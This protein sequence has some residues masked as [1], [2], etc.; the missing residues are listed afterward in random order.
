MK[1]LDDKRISQFLLATSLI[2]FA[3]LSFAA[4]SENFG[5]DWYLHQGDYK[6]QLLA[7]AGDERQRV[8]AERFDVRQKQL[9][10]PNLDRIDRC[11]TCHVAVDDP[12]MEDAEMPLAKHSGDLLLNHPKERFGCTICHRG[13]GRA[14]TAG[15]AH[16]HVPHWKEP[17]LPPSEL[18]RSCPKCHSEPSLPGVPRYNLAMKLLKEKSCLYCHKLR[19]QGGTRGPDISHAGENHDADWHFKHLKDPRSVVATSEMPD[20]KLSDEEARALTFLMMSYTGESIPTD[21]LSNP[22]PKPFKPVFDVDPLAM[23]GHVGSKVCIGCHRNLH[24]DA[25]DGWRKSRM[26]TT[27]ERIRDE[28]DKETCLSCHATGY[29]PVTTH[30]SEKGVACEA[31]HGPGQEAVEFALDGRVDEHKKRVRIGPD[32]KLVCARCHNPHMPV[33]KH[34]EE[35]RRQ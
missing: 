33:G 19:G 15:D 14:T 9:F 12:E 30:Y 29:N 34:I 35:F 23:K 11:I 2:T 27:Y 26:A 31:C 3:L 32:S 21:L 17:M 6:R 10:L 20:M 16:G 18:E 24:P 13:Q 25:V 1:Q 22:R 8:A 4:Y 28:P 7:R 5:A